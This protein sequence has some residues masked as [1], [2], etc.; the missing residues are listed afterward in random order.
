MARERWFWIQ[1]VLSVLYLHDDLELDRP[2][3]EGTLSVMNRNYRVWW[4]RLW[5]T[6]TLIIHQVRNLCQNECVR[7]REPKHS[8][9]LIQ[10]GKL[11]HIHYK[12]GFSGL[13]RDIQQD[14]CAKWCESR[15]YSAYEYWL[16]FWSR[17]C[18]LL[19]QWWVCLPWEANTQD[20]LLVPRSNDLVRWQR[21]NVMGRRM[22]IIITAICPNDDEPVIWSYN[23]RPECGDS[24][25]SLQRACTVLSRCWADT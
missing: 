25:R 20:P 11:R 8:E 19:M 10:R 18:C 6:E 22:I 21:I 24:S 14:K 23:F 9:I 16:V 13:P 4:I 17:Y 2:W 12:D 15:V 1:A 3:G 5:L 7:T